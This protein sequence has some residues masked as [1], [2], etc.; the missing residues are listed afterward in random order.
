M[1]IYAPTR[2]CVDKGCRKA[3]V[4]DSYGYLEGIFIEEM[5][6][7][8]PGTFD[9][10]VID[11]YACNPEHLKNGLDQLAEVAKA[12]VTAT[13]EQAGELLSAWGE[14]AGELA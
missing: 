12:M 5:W 3:L 10:L 6:W 1:K 7:A 13:A 4:T 2:Q 8:I 11:M 14:L 9:T